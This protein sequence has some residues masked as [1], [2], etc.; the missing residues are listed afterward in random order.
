METIFELLSAIV[1]FV[2]TMPILRFVF[3]VSLKR[4]FKY[5]R[6][7]AFL[8]GIPNGCERRFG[9]AIQMCSIR[10]FVLFCI[11]FDNSLLLSTTCFF[12]LLYL[13]ALTVELVTP[14]NESI[15]RILQ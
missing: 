6:E 15:K 12:V 13:E 14:N 10:G 2:S 7:E 9:M 5:F 8:F 11:I 3:F 4:L 1:S